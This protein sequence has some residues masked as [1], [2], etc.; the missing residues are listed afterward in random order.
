MFWNT[1][2]ELHRFQGL[3][4]WGL[5]GY[6]GLGFTG[7]VPGLGFHRVFHSKSFFVL[8]EPAPVPAGLHKADRSNGIEAKPGGSG[9]W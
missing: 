4:L 7:F 1:R 2:W 6:I 9:S 8:R 5:W 3:G